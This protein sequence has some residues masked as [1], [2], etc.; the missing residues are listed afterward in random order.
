MTSRFWEVDSMIFFTADLHFGHENIIKYNARPFRTIG[1][2]D[3]RLIG[4]WNERINE[5][6]I[7]Y[8]LGD[9]FFGNRAEP[10]E[11]LARLNGRKYLTPGNHEKSWIKHIDL[12]NYFEDVILMMEIQHSK[13]NILTLCHYPMM[14]WKDDRDG[15]GYMIHGHLHNR[16]DAEYFPLIRSNPNILNAGID[17]NDFRPVTFDELVKNNQKYKKSA[18]NARMGNDRRIWEE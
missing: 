2:M 9:L 17:V 16:T 8:I 13:Q 3:S 1:E 10:E 6:D 7:V 11:Y 4:N 15:T 12:S 14:C 18:I 5:D